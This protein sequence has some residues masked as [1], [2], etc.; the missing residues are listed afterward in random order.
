MKV[1]QG[2]ALHADDTLLFT[3]KL[4]R[5]PPTVRRMFSSP[6]KQQNFNQIE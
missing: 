4:T 1:K 2:H 5:E 6:I 3:Q